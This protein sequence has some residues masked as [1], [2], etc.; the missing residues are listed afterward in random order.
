[1]Q[2]GSGNSYELCLV[3]C[4]CIGAYV[5]N[6]KNQNQVLGVSFDFYLLYFYLDKLGT[7]LMIMFIWLQICWLWKKVGSD[8]DKGFQRFLDTTQYKCSGILRYERVFGSGFVSTGGL[9]RPS[10]CCFCLSFFCVLH[11]DGGSYVLHD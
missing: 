8:D 7:L 9:G 4:K 3:G 1:M 11:F 6:K 5:R 10:S 2:D